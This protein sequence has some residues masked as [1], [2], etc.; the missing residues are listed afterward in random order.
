MNQLASLLGMLIALLIA[1][2]VALG[3]GVAA[4]G[5]SRPGGLS[6]AIREGAAREGMGG[7]PI[8]FMFIIFA[9]LYLMWAT[10]PL[11]I[12]SSKQFD[13][14]RMLI[15]PISLRKLFAFD[16]I[17]EVTTLQS[18]FAIPALIA[19][20]IGAGLGSGNL[21]R[22]LLAAIPAILFG[23]ALSKWLS[24]TVGS[25]VRRKRAR[26]ETIVALV[27][28][29]AGLGGALAGQLGPMLLR[30]AESFRSLRW[31]PPGAAAYMLVHSDDIV[32]Y[33]LSLL[34]LAAYS[35][36]LIGGTYWIA[37]RSALGLGGA[38][39]RKSVTSE[40]DSIS[41]SG[42]D[43]PLL[44]PELSAIVEKEL[45]YAFRNA[46][47]RMMALM[48]LLLIIIRLVNS[49][50]F[51]SGMRT[52]SQNFLDYGAGLFATGGVLYVF[53]L[54]AGVSCNL[55]AFEEGGMRTFI[56]SPIERRK[57]LIGK[58]IAITIVALM[59][60]AALLAINAIVFRDVTLQ[61]LL[62]VGLSF[63]CFATLISLIGNWFSISFPKRMEFGKRLNVS[64]VAGF[65][66]LPTVLLLAIPPMAA[67][68]AGYMMESMLAQFAILAGCAVLT[69]C[70]YLVMI[71]FQGRSLE[72]REIDI[73]EVVKERSD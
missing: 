21:G 52:P 60:S 71:N 14:A 59:F 9:F 25:L 5:L 2:A 28:A 15:Y 66:L 61:S 30:H 62:F 34:T 48:P 23:M 31:T 24:T 6:T 55:F 39:R 20:G 65:L 32:G 45:R 11:S 18:V 42:W 3:L 7:E 43:L 37:R 47:L 10:V 29:C 56:L 69:S 64:G 38:R 49:R 36:V 33:I 73:L 51:E 17:S 12:G 13:A 35:V 67:T 63:V 40:P 44:S 70:I 53:L 1:L 16:F 4:Y 57:I 72:R 27:G 41:Y 8:Q 26:G 46:Q 58:N 19:M 22:T 54:L 50:R 68:L